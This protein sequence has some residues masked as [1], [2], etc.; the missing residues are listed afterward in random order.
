MILETLANE[1]SMFEREEAD[2]W[3]IAETGH[4]K[5]KL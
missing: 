4:K 3:W 1:K 2:V 5:N